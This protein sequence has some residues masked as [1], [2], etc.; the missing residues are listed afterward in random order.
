M[1]LSAMLVEGVEGGMETDG[2]EQRLTQ[3][4]QNGI[5]ANAGGMVGMAQGW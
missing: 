4:T 2:S 5:Y 1:L 3:P